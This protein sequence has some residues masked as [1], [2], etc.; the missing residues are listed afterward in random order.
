MSERPR[1][2]VVP[3]RVSHDLERHLLPKVP[4]YQPRRAHRLLPPGEGIADVCVAPR[5]GGVFRAA[6]ELAGFAA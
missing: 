4:P 5:D 2:G 3:I 6:A 1:I